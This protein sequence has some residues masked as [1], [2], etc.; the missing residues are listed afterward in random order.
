M[1]A[2]ISTILTAIASALVGGG[3]AYIVG[4]LKLKGRVVDI[5]KWRCYI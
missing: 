1:G 3:I 4:V 2:I 5:E